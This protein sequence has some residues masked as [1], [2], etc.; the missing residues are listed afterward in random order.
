M[1]W[2]DD[3]RRPS[4]LPCEGRRGSLT[5]VENAGFLMKKEARSIINYARFL[6]QN[7]S[8]ND[9]YLPWEMRV[10]LREEESDRKWCQTL[11]RITKTHLEK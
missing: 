7:R 10:H 11:N 1:R 8:E 2:L 9:C 3:G 4:E 5:S 6:Y